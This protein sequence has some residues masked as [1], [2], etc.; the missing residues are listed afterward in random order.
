MVQVY[1][2]HVVKHRIF[3]QLVKTK[4]FRYFTVLLKD[5]KEKYL[6]NN[7]LSQYSVTELEVHK[8]YLLQNPENEEWYR[9]K[10]LKLKNPNEVEIL[11]I[12]I[13]ENIWVENKN[14]IQLEKLSTILA[15][16][17]NQVSSLSRFV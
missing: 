6:N 5:I 2:S 16:Y 12:D 14:F 11:L 8:I 10:V 4:S 3:V 15:K 7:S 17:P 1:I 13:G 9:V